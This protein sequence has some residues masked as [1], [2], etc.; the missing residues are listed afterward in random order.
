LEYNIPRNA[1]TSSTQELNVNPATGQGTSCPGQ[2]CGNPLFLS[3]N[4]GWRK[5]AVGNGEM[6]A[7]VGTAT[8]GDA[9]GYAFWSVGNLGGQSPN[10]RYLQ[11]DGIDPINLSYVDGTL[12]SCT[13]PCPGIVSFANVSAGNY[14][15]WNTLRLVSHKPIPAGVSALIAR[16]QNQVV[17][18]Y[19][20]FLPMSAMGV[21][22]SHYKQSN[23]LG[24]DGSG[25]ACTAPESGGDVGGAVLTIQ[26]DQ[27]YCAATGVKAGRNGLKQ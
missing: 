8:N 13:A 2:P 14:P 25:G 5:R 7:Q 3:N 4:A 6:V 20:D 9:L 1:E 27:D 12:P 22:R 21:L 24:A 10:I 23:V 11:V 16:A 19:P 26:G 15:I 18:I 17:N